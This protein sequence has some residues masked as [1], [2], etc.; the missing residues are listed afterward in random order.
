MDDHK[1]FIGYNL[2]VLSRFKTGEI[3]GAIFSP[4]YN[5]RNCRMRGQRMYHNSFSDNIDDSMYIVTMIKLFIALDR[6]VKTTGYLAVNLPNSKKGGNSVLYKVLYN[7]QQETRWMVF[8]CLSWIKPNAVPLKG[9]QFNRNAESVY[10]FIKKPHIGEYKLEHK[11]RE[12][13]ATFRSNTIFAKNN[14]GAYQHGGTKCNAR[15]SSDLVMELLNRLAK[16]GQTVLDPYLGSGSTLMACE[17]FGCS[18]IG[19]EL[20]Q[21]HLDIRLLKYIV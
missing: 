12:L 3:D 11:V 19:V 1:I 8:D 2:N 9:S 5:M 16:P 15:Y 7:I 20:V 13:P 17:K 21:E 14:N 10:I 18:C 4:P 6:V